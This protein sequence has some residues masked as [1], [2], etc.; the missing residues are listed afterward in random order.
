MPAE[1]GRLVLVPSTGG[2]GG[3]GGAT[4]RSRLGGGD[5]ASSTVAPACRA[6]RGGGGGCK[7]GGVHVRRP[8]RSSAWT[9]PR[10]DRKGHGPVVCT[11]CSSNEPRRSR[12]RSSRWRLRPCRQYAKSS[13]IS[14]EGPGSMIM[15]PNAPHNARRAFA[16][17]AKPN[18]DRAARSRNS[19]RA[20][21][22]AAQLYLLLPSPQ[23]SPD[24]PPGY[25]SPSIPM[26]PIRLVPRCSDVAAPC[27]PRPECRRVCGLFPPLPYT[28][29][30]RL[31]GGQRLKWLALPS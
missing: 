18:T 8:W 20:P 23:I 4:A 13:A 6:R 21:S 12:L 27:H 30:R 29:W 3:R 14:W 9:G 11:S 25:G 26:L 17:A 5:C 1:P 15:W 31:S 24:P 2:A 10:Q 28:R 16:R 19:T 22:R 7:G